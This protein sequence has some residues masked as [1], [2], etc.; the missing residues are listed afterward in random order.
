MGRVNFRSIKH[1]EVYNNMM[2]SAEADKEINRGGGWHQPATLQ[3]WWLVFV[4]MGRGYLVPLQALCFG[5]RNFAVEALQTALPD[6][7]ASQRVRCTLRANFVLAEQNWPMGSSRCPFQPRQRVFPSGAITKYSA[8]IANNN[9]EY[10]RTV[11]Q[12]ITPPI[13]GGVFNASLAAARRGTRS[14]QSL[15]AAHGSIAPQSGPNLNCAFDCG[16]IRF[17]LTSMLLR[18]HT[19][20]PPSADQVWL[21]KSNIHSL[22]Q[23]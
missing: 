23:P 19:L 3:L 12:I 4:G 15:A 16:S 21:S 14:Q 5:R 20:T 6:S 9:T 22:P 7:P 17:G 2:E 1:Y 11:E 13:S 18:R 8:Y 10:I